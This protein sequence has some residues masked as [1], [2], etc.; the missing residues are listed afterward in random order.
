MNGLSSSAKDYFAAGGLGILLFDGQLQ[1]YGSERILKTS[2]LL[3]KLCKISVNY[4]YI[5]NPAY[6][7]DHRSVS[8]LDFAHMLSF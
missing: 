7:A 6:V 1:N 4:Q 8:I 5:V 3:S 2:M